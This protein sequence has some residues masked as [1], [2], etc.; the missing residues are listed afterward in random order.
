L[1]AVGAAVVVA[2]E[3]LPVLGW[4]LKL[5]VILVG[6]GAVALAAWNAR[7]GMPE[8]GRPA[9]GTPATQEIAATE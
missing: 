7:R 6:V 5:A 2:V 9:P 4:A 8:T 3:T 1:L